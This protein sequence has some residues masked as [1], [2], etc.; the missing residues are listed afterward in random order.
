MKKPYKYQED[1]IKCIVEYFKENDRGKIIL[2]CGSGK[3]LI[4]LWTHEALKSKLTIVLVPSI[5]LIKQT[6]DNW[7]EEKNIDFN[8]LCV[9]SSQDVDEDDEEEYDEEFIEEPVFKVTTDSNI[10]KSFLLANTC[11]NKVIFSTYQ[12]LDKVIKAIKDEE[13]VFDLAICDEAHRTAGEIIN[14]KITHFKKIHSNDY[15]KVKK[16]LYMTAT[17]R[18]VNTDYYNTDDDNKNYDNNYNSQFNQV[19]KYINENVFNMDD[20]KTFGDVIYQMSFQKAIDEN[21]LVDYKIIGVGITDLEI[22]NYIKSGK[23]IDKNISYQDIADNYACNLIMEKYNLKHAITFHS[24]IKKAENFADRHKQFFKNFDSYCISSKIDA[25]KRN[26]IMLNFKNSEKSLIS[27]A[28]CLSEGVDIPK[29]DM[30]FYSNIKK[31]TIDI[32]Q[33]AGRALR[34]YKDKDGKEK[35]FGYIVI[36]IYYQEKLS[37]NNFDTALDN[38]FENVEYEEEGTNK[39]IKIR[40]KDLNEMI[41]IIKKIGDEDERIESY[42]NLSF[43]DFK[44]KNN[45]INKKENEEEHEEDKKDSIILENFNNKQIEEA[46]LEKIIKRSYGSWSVNFI[47]LKQFIEN[48]DRLPEETGNNSEQRLYEWL[49]KQKKL[50]IN[51]E[52]N[53]YKI[54]KLQSVEKISFLFCSEIDLYNKFWDYSFKKLKEYIINNA[55]DIHNKFFN[56]NSLDKNLIIVSYL[57]KFLDLQNSYYNLNELEYLKLREFLDEKYLSTLLT[58]KKYL[59]HKREIIKYKI[60]LKLF[61]YKL[62]INKYHFIILKINQNKFNIQTFV[63]LNTIFNETVIIFKE[64]SKLKQKLHNI[65]EEYIQYNIENIHILELF[66]YNDNYFILKNA[67]IIIDLYNKSYDFLINIKKIKQTIRKNLNQYIKEFDNIESKYSVLKD[68]DKKLNYIN[69]EINILK[70]FNKKHAIRKYNYYVAKNRI[71]YKELYTEYKRYCDLNFLL[72]LNEYDIK[73]LLIFEEKLLIL[74]LKEEQKQYNININKYKIK[75]LINN[76]KLNQNIVIAKYSQ[77]IKEYKQIKVIYDTEIKFIKNKLDKFLNNRNI[78]ELNDIIT[79]KKDNGKMFK[80]KIVDSNSCIDNDIA[81]V[82]KHTLYGEALIGVA[83]NE[84]V[85]IEKKNGIES[86]EI[87]KIEKSK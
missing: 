50:F 61:H 36:P 81:I 72:T 54:S 31:S 33:S 64:L 45:K 77:L 53:S 80:I 66:L 37:D 2:P 1:V 44:K 48:R 71:Y 16:R 26:E 52:L 63:K 55:N 59:L 34:K 22:E 12:S 41:N 6:K 40:K 65:R 70:H 30:I 69:K 67:K 9:C 60:K 49:E 8:Y 73:Q 14:S 58:N 24:K 42:I 79:L 87:L 28:R 56:I 84:I 39:K 62:N 19:Y 4:S 15:I 5:S 20:I 7:K 78:V 82:N 32:V 86:I 23:I 21:I 85:D 13:L 35:E 68:I 51:N 74:K 57:L 47:E 76:W 46:I 75:N 38:N 27:N 25:D 3:T 29:V 18:V 17:P 83:L 10:I 11:K 43:L